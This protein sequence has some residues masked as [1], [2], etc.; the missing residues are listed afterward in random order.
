MNV[1]PVVRVR[2]GESRFAE[3]LCSYKIGVMNYS[4]TDTSD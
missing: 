2:T 4:Y 1:F 3:F